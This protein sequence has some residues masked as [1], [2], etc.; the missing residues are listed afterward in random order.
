MLIINADDF[1]KSRFSTDRILECFREGRI[2]AA[3]GMVF[4]ADSERAA[5]LAALNNLDVGLHAN[6][7]LAFDN[8]SDTDL[9]RIQKR[10]SRFLNGCKYSILIYNP[11][12]TISFRVL[13][14][15]QFSE[16]VRL[17]SAPP[18]H[19]DGHQHFHLC[20]NMLVDLPIPKGN[21]VR[22]NFTF[23]SKEKNAL[24]RAYR[25]MVDSWIRRKYT[26]VDYFFDILPISD[27]RMNFIA[28][29]AKHSAVELMVHPDR[30]EEYSYI[31][32]NTFARIL[33]QLQLAG[34]RS[35]GK[36]K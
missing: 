28:D 5:N 22:R 7:T 1:G 8:V 17:Y 20:A 2:T 18:S 3:S 29:C 15:A 4:M 27:T 11:F 21:T 9:V 31:M 25:R 30:D 34:F 10:A 19:V 23:A 33:G 14:A 13:F 36:C 32:G 12:L 16:Y 35:F 6:F 26:T 24:N